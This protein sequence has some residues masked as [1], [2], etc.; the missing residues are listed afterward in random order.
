MLHTD[1]VLNLGNDLHVPLPRF[2]QTT[3]SQHIPCTLHER[4][5][6]EI[7]ILMHAKADILQVLSHMRTIDIQH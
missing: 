7:H 4:Y 3:D 5:R 1:Q 6:H 2:D